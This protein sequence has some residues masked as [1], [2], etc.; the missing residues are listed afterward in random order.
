M[1]FL[2]SI[3]PEK[4]A[5]ADSIRKAKLAET[6]T[7]IS[8]MSP[9][10][11]LDMVIRYIITISLKILAALVIYF[12]GRWII[13]RIKKV[14]QRIFERRKVEISLRNFILSLVSAT[15]MILLILTVIGI[16]GINTT[17]FIALLAS[18]GLAI[19]MAL[20]G[21]MQNFAGGV[22]LLMLKQYRVGDF[23]E[24]QGYT[25]TVKEIRL[26]NTVINT[27]DNK[28]IIIPN[29]GISTNIINNYSKEPIRRVEWI[30]GIS[31][32]DDYEEAKAVMTSLLEQDPR[33]L[34]EPPFLVALNNLGDS[35]VNIVARAWCKS[36]DYW[37]LHFDINQRVYKTFPEHG[38]SFPFPQMDIHLIKER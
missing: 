29:S 8:Q 5:E 18:A 32:G 33:V 27:T 22:M 11:I 7:Q 25:G 21:T 23:I 36:E 24:F 26:F 1:L 38:L 10:E 3:D 17:S 34:K 30:I 14:L 6:I 15:L 2:Q 12:I 37:D 31:Y 16:L 19:G 35:S 13:R 4:I 9:Q 20:S 28:T